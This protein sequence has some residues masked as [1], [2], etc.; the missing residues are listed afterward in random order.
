MDE[1]TCNEGERVV[2]GRDGDDTIAVSVRESDEEEGEIIDGDML[3][4]LSS[5]ILNR[6]GS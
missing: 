4:G 2:G 1:R 6:L 3:E 5:I